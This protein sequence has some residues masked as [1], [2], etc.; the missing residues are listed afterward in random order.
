MERS[1]I[2]NCEMI[3]EVGY[4]KEKELLEVV[5]QSGEVFQFEDVPHNIFISF[6]T[7]PSHYNFYLEYI[8]SHYDY[9]IVHENEE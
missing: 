2:E 4:D 3:C 1:K 8:K 5:F 7:A 9:K 6:M